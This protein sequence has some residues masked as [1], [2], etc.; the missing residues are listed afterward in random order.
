MNYEGEDGVRKLTFWGI[1]H[2]IGFCLVAAMA[3]ISHLKAMCTD[4]GAVPPDAEPV[5]DSLNANGGRVEEGIDVPRKKP[6]RLCRR[7]NSFKPDRA[8]HCSICKRCIIK[9]DHHC[10]WVNNC[11]GIG[12]HKYFLLFILYTFFS[13]TYSMFLVI[14]R[15]TYCLRGGMN[16]ADPPCLDDPANLVG[17]I[18]LVVESMLF[19]LFTLCM[20]A[21]QWD[22]VLTNV[23]HID[24]L[25]G[26]IFESTGDHKGVNE[27]FGIGIGGVKEKKW[28]TCRTDWLSPFTKV[29]FPDSVEDEIMGFCRPCGF[30]G[31]RKEEEELEILRPNSG[32]EEIV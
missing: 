19:G 13:C 26:D 14:L 18:A 1:F 5:P 20:M 17:I 8:H 23:T 21:D 16:H 12:N 31:K 22:V 29:C 32:N 11:V 3:I 28:A 7:C 25:K 4:P 15:F 9:M 10:P 2:S 24:R 27:V 6:K 30:K